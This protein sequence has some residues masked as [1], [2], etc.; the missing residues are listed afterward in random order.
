MFL[1]PSQVCSFSCEPATRFS[2]SS[3]PTP[4]PTRNSIHEATNGPPGRIPES[5]PRDFAGRGR[6][7]A[8]GNLPVSARQCYP[9]N[10]LP[11]CERCGERMAT[12]R[13]DVRASFFG[14]FE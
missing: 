3:P 5:C 1:T 2:L 9:D 13:N 8:G 12:C 14:S 7:I 10:H 6:T 11:G 4:S